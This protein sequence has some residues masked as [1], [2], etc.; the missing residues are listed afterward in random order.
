MGMGELETG[1]AGFVSFLGMFVVGVAVYMFIVGDDF[2]ERAI[3]VFTT[4][5]G[6][7]IIVTSVFM[8]LGY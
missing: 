6:I 8:F 1:M 4:L 5:I 7:V 2:V 3:A